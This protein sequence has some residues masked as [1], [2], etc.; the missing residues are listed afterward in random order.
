[1]ALCKQLEKQM[2]YLTT[3][4]NDYKIRFQNTEQIILKKDTLFISLGAAVACLQK[5]Q[6]KLRTENKSTTLVITELVKK[7]KNVLIRIRTRG[8]RHKNITSSI[9]RHL[10]GLALEVKGQILSCVE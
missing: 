7:S 6:E 8:N 2:E 5:G 4:L 3:P 9:P 1:M 10:P